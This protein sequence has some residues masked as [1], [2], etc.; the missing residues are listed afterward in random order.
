[1]SLFQFKKDITVSTE[2]K[3]IYKKL[4]ERFFNLFKI[5]LGKVKQMSEISVGVLTQCI[6]STTIFGPKF[7]DQT[8]GNIL[9]KINTKLSGTNHSIVSVPNV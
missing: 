3:N 5:I 8:V 7:N 6:K 2:S 9:L 4:F 1:M